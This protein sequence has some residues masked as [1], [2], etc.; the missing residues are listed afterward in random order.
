MQPDGGNVA[1]TEFDTRA[2][3]QDVRGSSSRS[4]M[5]E[6]LGKEALVVFE[7]TDHELHIHFYQD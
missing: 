7:R 1:E 4:K 6:F 3:F 5:Q 2:P